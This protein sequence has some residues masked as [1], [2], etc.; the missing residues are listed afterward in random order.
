MLGALL[1]LPS[2]PTHHIQYPQV[3]SFQAKSPLFLMSIRALEVGAPR[4]DVRRNIPAATTLIGKN[5]KVVVSGN[6]SD[7]LRI[8]VDGVEAG[9][10]RERGG[11]Q[12]AAV[13]QFTHR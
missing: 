13:V 12:R 9:V 6:G 11:V 1:T 5:G 2:T 4:L 3:Q 10:D 7:E 8:G